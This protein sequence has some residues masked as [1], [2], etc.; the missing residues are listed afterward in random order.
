MNYKSTLLSRDN[1]LVVCILL[2]ALIANVLLAFFAQEGY[3]DREEFSNWLL[4]ELIKLYSEFEKKFISLW[5]AAAA[6][7]K[8]ELFKAG[9]AI[10]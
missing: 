4:N 5:D 9:L 3:G 1:N 6:A 7:G 2:G 10:H 8:G